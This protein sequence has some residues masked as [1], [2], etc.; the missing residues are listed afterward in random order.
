MT[1]WEP[2]FNWVLE[3]GDMLYIPPQVGHNGIGESDDCM[4]YS[5]GFRA[6]SHAE[7]MR[8]F[9]DFVG[10]KLTSE[11]RY[12]DPDLALQENSGEITPEA[13]EKVR[14]IFTDYLADDTKLA[15]WLGQYV[16]DPKY[17]DLDQAPEEPISID[18]LRT[19]LNESDLYF[20]RNE[21]ARFSYS[22]NSEDEL[23]FFADGRSFQLSGTSCTLAANLCRNPAIVINQG[24]WS[25][26]QLQLLVDL[27]NQGSIYL[28]D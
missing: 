17:P 27:F 20:V 19:A 12:T 25:E 15:Q 16:T 23:Q 18:Q 7:I 24:E 5:V 8:S 28:E 6:P 3:P 2:E 1:E 22:L 13:I 26:Q 11:S 10:E 14:Q 4:T 21:G 9:T